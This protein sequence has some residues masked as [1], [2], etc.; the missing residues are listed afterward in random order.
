MGWGSGGWG[1]LAWGSTVLTPLPFG[2]GGSELTILPPNGPLE[3]GTLVQLLSPSILNMESVT[4]DFSDG[5]LDLSF[6]TLIS[7]GSGAATELGDAQAIRLDTGTTPGS[8]A[9][10]RTQLAETNID[11]E[12]DGV[13]VDSAGPGEATV[14]EL[15]LVK[16]VSSVRLHVDRDGDVHLTIVSNGTAYRRTCRALSGWRQCG[17]TVTSRLKY[18]H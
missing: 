16:T 5:V 14:F 15:A 1:S 3:G 4:P 2:A 9:G 8:L 6:W 12:I 17:K 18:A 7:T 11:I 13:T 10:L